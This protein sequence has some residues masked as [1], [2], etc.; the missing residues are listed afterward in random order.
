MG[1]AAPKAAAALPQLP[2]FVNANRKISSGK[3]HLILARPGSRRP[4]T[5]WKMIPVSVLRRQ[6]RASAGGRGPVSYRQPT[7]SIARLFCK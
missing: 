1:G 4:A 7:E 5:R 3:R 2:T 6:M